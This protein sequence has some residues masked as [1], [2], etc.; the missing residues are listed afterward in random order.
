MLRTKSFRLLV[1]ISLCLFGLSAYAADE[2][3]GGNKAEAKS[4][5]GEL[6]EGSCPVVYTRSAMDQKSTT[7]GVSSSTIDTDTKAGAH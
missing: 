6:S 4:V 7:A 1:A 2:N 3:E 5:E